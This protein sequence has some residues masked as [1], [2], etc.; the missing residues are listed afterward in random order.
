MDEYIKKGK[1]G[2]RK[3][4]MVEFEIVYC[5]C[6]EVKYFLVFFIEFIYY[7]KL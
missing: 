3:Y 6:L 5:R 2:Y 1:I 7:V 4:F